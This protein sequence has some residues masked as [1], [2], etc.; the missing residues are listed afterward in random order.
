MY[1][2]VLPINLFRGWR[3]STRPVSG[4][5]GRQR[6]PVSELWHQFRLLLFRALLAGNLSAHLL[7]TSFPVLFLTVHTA[8]DN[9]ATTRALHIVG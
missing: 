9:A 7:V 1:A 4:G 6:C 3:R 2:N 8:E 5:V